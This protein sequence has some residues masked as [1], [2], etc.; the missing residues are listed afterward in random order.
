M[1]MPTSLRFLEAAWQGLVAGAI[2]D[3][4]IPVSN[5]DWGFADRQEW[6]GGLGIARIN[7]NDSYQ[8]SGDLGLR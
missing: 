5:R 3:A 1:L 6:G 4:D 2:H 8:T 7:A